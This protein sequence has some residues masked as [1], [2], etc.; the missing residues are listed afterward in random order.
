M[1]N[2]SVQT[3][4]AWEPP[5]EPPCDIYEEARRTFIEGKLVDIAEEIVRHGVH[6]S[7]LSREADDVLDVMFEYIEDNIEKFEPEV[8]D[9]I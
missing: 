2:V 8:P 3:P 9:E 1:Y 7:K 5:L 6:S 4:F